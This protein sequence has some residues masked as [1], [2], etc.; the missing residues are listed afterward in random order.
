MSQENKR[1]LSTICDLATIVVSVIT[2][3]AL[4]ILLLLA[5]N[6][7]DDLEKKIDEIQKAHELFL[8]S[9][10]QK[11]KRIAYLTDALCKMRKLGEFIEI[12]FKTEELTE[13]ASE[14]TNSYLK[15]NL[16]LM[17]EVA[18]MQLMSTYGIM[19]SLYYDI[20][21]MDVK[22]EDVE[23]DDYLTKQCKD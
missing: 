15:V 11:V 1:P 4:L 10:D 7:V 6:K 14:Q 8:P 2:C 23:M 22:F 17:H 9:D 13:M 12:S 16:Y 18:H 3:V 21:K 19:S 20:T 5:N